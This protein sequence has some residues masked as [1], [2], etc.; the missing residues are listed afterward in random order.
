MARILIIDDDVHILAMLRMMLEREN[1]DVMDA[2][3]GKEGLKRHRKAPADLIITDIF[4]PEKD[5]IET[6]RELRRDFP[7]VSIIAM[8][9]G[10]KNDLGTYLGVAKALGA[11]YTFA[12]PFENEEL[13][14]AVRE[15]L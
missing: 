7:G 14:N 9:G 1:Y 6:I 3:N 12:K 2:I 5:G 15:I 11:L 4:M 10:G 8:S 13:L